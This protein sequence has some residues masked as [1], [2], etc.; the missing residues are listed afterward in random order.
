MT[1]IRAKDVILL[2]SLL[3]FSAL[4]HWYLSIADSPFDKCLQKAD[5]KA[6]DCKL[7]SRD[8]EACEATR[9]YDYEG[10]EISRDVGFGPTGILR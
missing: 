7:F 6:E 8:D 3:S 2:V 9:D 10:C 4:G 1:R 5:K